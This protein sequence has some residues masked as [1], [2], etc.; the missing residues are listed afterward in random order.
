MSTTR[1]E[2]SRLGLKRYTSDKP[3]L[4]C[5]GVERYVSSNRCP[6][7]TIQATTKRYHKNRE[8]RQKY[9]RDY[10]RNNPEKRQALK[11]HRRASKINATPKWLTENDFNSIREF[12]AETKACKEFEEIYFGS[13]EDFHV[14]HI[15]PLLGNT[16]CGL[17]VPWNLQ[18]LPASENLKKGNRLNV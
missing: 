1:S 2:A 18:V 10:N 8:D 6:T 5:R 7:C 16:V 15:V 12:Y 13:S 3:C 14:D 4:K 11:A 17:H 9:Q